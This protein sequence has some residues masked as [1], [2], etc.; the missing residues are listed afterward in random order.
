MTGPLWRVKTGAFNP[1]RGKNIRNHQAGD[2][3]SS[4]SCVTGGKSLSVSV[5][6]FFS[7]FPHPGHSVTMWLAGCSMLPSCV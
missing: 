6:K 4:L 1:D 7:L 3:E 2:L 5:P